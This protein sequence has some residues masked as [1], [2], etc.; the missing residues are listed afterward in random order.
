MTRVWGWEPVLPSSRLPQSWLR[1]REST[2]KI[3]QWFATI[4]RLDFSWFSMFDCCKLLT[5]SSCWCIL[6]L[7]PPTSPW[8]KFP[9]NFLLIDPSFLFLSSSILLYLFLS[10]SRF[11]SVL[12]HFNH[13]SP[14]SYILFLYFLSVLYVFLW[15]MPNYGWN[16]VIAFSFPNAGFLLWQE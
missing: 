5:V 3:F 12:H 13:V 9:W 1:A 2:D 15:Q 16:Q 7:F 11:S 10:L 14:V 4:F 6:W 8:K